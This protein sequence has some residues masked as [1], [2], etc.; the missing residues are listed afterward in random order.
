MKIVR[1]LFGGFDL[2]LFGAVFLLS[3]LGLV[4]MFTFEGENLFFERQIIWIGLATVALIAATIPDY[5]FLRGGNTIFY[6]FLTVIVLLVLVLLIGTTVKGAQSRFDIGFFAVQPSEYAKLVLIAVLAKYFSKR[7][8]Y[9][10]DFKHILISGAYAFV[11][12]ALVAVQPDFGSAIIIFAIWF[13]MVLVSGISF[14]HLAIVGTAGVLAFTLL[15]N[16]G[17]QEYQK[18]R[19]MTFLNPLA[20]IQGT[21]YNAYQSTIAVGSG[22][23][24]GKGVGYGTQ[25]KLQY[26]PEYETDFIFAAFAEEW[27]MFGAAVLFGLFGIVIWRLLFHAVHGATNFERLFAVGVAVFFMSHFVVHV[28]MNIGLLPVTGTTIPFLSYGGSHLLTE[29]V[30]VGMVI[31]MS[32]YTSTHY[33]TVELL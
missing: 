12:F 23:F 18:D 21:G 32:R 27:G 13:G 3:L 11:P 29:F 28:G 31:A 6:L 25:S 30:A 4:T 2:W 19:I 7:H 1:T 9:I 8:E 20:D 16:V 14:R 26:L 22:Q 33:T 15:W 10:G 17:F 5:R 24:L